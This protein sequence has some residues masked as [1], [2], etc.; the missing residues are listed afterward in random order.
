MKEF[1]STL[2]ISPMD[3]RDTLIIF[4]EILDVQE[5]I[6]SD[7]LSYQSIANAFKENKN[8]AVPRIMS[9]L[10]F[11]EICPIWSSNSNPK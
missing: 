1:E 11:S 4:K 7:K 2:R 5:V 6:Q 9:S 10:Y 3:R 8:L